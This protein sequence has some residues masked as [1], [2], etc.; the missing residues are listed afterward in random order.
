MNINNKKEIADSEL[1]DINTVRRIIDGRR[2]VKKS[3]DSLL[4]LII[5]ICGAITVLAGLIVIIGYIFG[6]YFLEFV[7]KNY[8]PMADE[9][10]FSFLII[11]TVLIFFGKN[12]NEPGLRY[13]LFGSAA[14]LALMGILTL[15]DA[16]SNHIYNI[17]DFLFNYKQK[18]N[19]IPIGKMSSI[20][21]V[22]FLLQGISLLLLG[23]KKVRFS[24]I[25]SLI[26]LIG[27][28]IILI[29]YWFGVPYFYREGFIPIAL[30]TA[31]F[32][33]VSATGLLFAAGR[34]SFPLRLF[35]GESTQARLMRG[36]MPVILLINLINDWAAIL[37]V[38]HFDSYFALR[39]SL[40]DISYLFIAGVIVSLI[41]RKIGKS[42]DNTIAERKRVEE[43]LRE[44]EKL[45]LKISDNFPNSY[46]SII[47]K[48]LII[49]F[50]S[51]QEFKKQN[52]N[53]DDF[54]GLTIE[55]VFGEHSEFVRSQYMKS[56]NG[57]ETSFEL[58]INNQHQL[59]KTVPLIA[60]DGSIPQILS[61][62]E[63]ITER[64]QTEEERELIAH[65]LQLINNP[66]DFNKCISDLTASLQNWSG[67]EAVGIRLRDGD[68][69]PYYETRGFPPKFVQMEKYLCMYDRNG[70]V[71]RDSVGNPILECMCGNVICGRFNPE[72]PFFT[73]NGSFWSNNTTALLASTTE[74]DR[75]A[76]TR[77]RCNGEGYESVALIPL[78]MGNQFF[79]LIQ[80]NDKRPDRFSHGI[81]AHF[82]RLADNL[83]IA[84]SGR[85]TDETL[86]ESEE[87]YRNLVEN[88]HEALIIE[89]VEGR[90]IFVNDTFCKMFGFSS[91]EKVIL[92][93]KDYTSPDYFSEIMERHNQRM[94]GNQAD[95]EFV[96]KGI[97][98]DGSEIWIEARVSLLIKDGKI[99]G[100]Q[101]LERDI[102]ERKMTEE[103]LRKSET[104]LAN[105]VGI[106]KLGPWEYDVQSDTFTFNDY[107]Y[108]IFRTT[109]E[110]EGGYTMSSAQYAQRFLYP[111][112]MPLVALETQKALETDDPNFSR[113]LEHRI[114]Y[115]DGEIGY[116]SVQ[117]LI[118][119]DKNGKTIKTFGANQDITER[120]QA[121][122]ALRESEER[123]KKAQEV[124]N[125]GSWEYDI[126]NDTFWGSDEGKKIYVF[127]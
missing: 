35:L 54:V 55:Q 26:V 99:I 101:S 28:Y 6:D 39:E 113:Q 89:D 95:N 60:G 7:G 93:L 44:N 38:R 5:I 9:T 105:A 20:T 110:R 12:R 114:I 2:E 34:E 78:R 70:E 111:D 13:I 27:G 120:K 116:L 127:N 92:T 81:I 29:A 88:I 80:F 36:F 16:A 3:P 73:E 23:L 46:L 61:V 37:E 118:L 117:F 103:A 76:R 64:K 8:V 24:T 90:T 57:E 33:L 67:C 50:S 11:G 30:S 58:F 86:K 75:Q 100:T 4:N 115:A 32:M 77:N 123:Y 42:I 108:A 68:D 66:G 65:L 74:V 41:S 14:I 107:F 48:D 47:N 45:L 52:L 84:L 25:F 112:D 71:K 106:A 21:A 19:N 121:D 15:A 56:F 22:C 126:V 43:E 98:K 53:P 97:R 51:G 85:L 91:D 79:G 83:S 119:K 125:I 96:Y 87:K 122:K 124:G 59:Y 109:A 69:Y 49:G 31:I 62:V 63:N 1:S 104:Q 94:Q 18:I 40:I 17:S 10:A 102:T 72:K 82:E